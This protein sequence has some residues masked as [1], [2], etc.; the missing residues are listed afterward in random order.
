MNV[1]VIN[2]EKSIDRKAKISKNLKECGYENVSYFKAIEPKDIQ[3]YKNLYNKDF[4]YKNGTLACALSH[5]SLL[6]KIKDYDLRSPILIL[7]DDIIVRKSCKSVIYLLSDFLNDTDPNWDILYLSWGLGS[8]VHKLWEGQKPL[9]IKNDSIYSW[10]KIGQLVNYYF[11]RKIKNESKIVEFFEWS[12]IYVDWCKNDIF[13]YASFQNLINQSAY[14]IN[15]KRINNIISNIVPLDEAIDIKIFKNLNNINIYM[16]SPSLNIIT[17]DPDTSKESVRL[18]YDYEKNIEFLWPKNNDVL[19]KN[20]DY[21]FKLLVHKSLIHNEDYH[22]IKNKCSI[23]IND[24]K[25]PLEINIDYGH[26]D[27]SEISLILDKTVLS[28]LPY[29]NKMVFTFETFWKK[30]KINKNISFFV[31]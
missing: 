16:L 13:K 2:L 12:D 17:P 18:D 24:E 11:I 3:K 21:C 31:S 1:F 9:D 25:V 26:G 7:E 6:I 28:T 23:L 14:I 30:D 15:P 29:G 22:F 10:D 4:K 5:V 20:Y 8:N 27:F 19:N